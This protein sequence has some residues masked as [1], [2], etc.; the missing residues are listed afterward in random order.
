MFLPVL[1][2]DDCIRVYNTTNSK[3][4]HVYFL[5]MLSFLWWHQL[6]IRCYLFVICCRSTYEHQSWSPLCEALYKCRTETISVSKSL[7]IKIMNVCPS[8]TAILLTL[9]DSTESHCGIYDITIVSWVADS[10]DFTTGLSMN[11]GWPEEE[12]GDG[13]GSKEV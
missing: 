1:K 11:M 9:H 5:C 12:D 2:G 3:K 6:I 8:Q 7:H 10:Y 4:N 13:G